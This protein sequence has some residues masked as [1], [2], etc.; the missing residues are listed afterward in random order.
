MNNNNNFSICPVCTSSMRPI[1]EYYSVCDAC[2][3][4]LSNEPAGAGAEV[5]SLEA[6][7]ERNFRFICEV[8][9]EKLHIPNLK[10]V[11]DVGSSTGHFL[12]IANDLGF[13]ATG[14]EADI[15]L[16]NETQ[17]RGLT[18]INGFFPNAGGLGE[19]KYDMLCSGII[20]VIK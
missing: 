17:Q 10:K 3:Y 12:D 16:A 18:V 6:V 4:M 11:L 20:C 19:Q 13:D 7:R 15:Y 1:A 14:L 5:V 9:K 8:I 2:R